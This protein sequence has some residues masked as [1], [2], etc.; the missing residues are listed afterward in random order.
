[1]G[2]QMDQ[3]TLEKAQDALTLRCREVFGDPDRWI[4]STGYPKSMAL[5]VLNS[6]YS[7]GGNYSATTNV[8]ARYLKAREQEGANAYRDSTADLLAAVERWGGS[9]EFAKVIKNERPASPRSKTPV[10]KAEVVRRAAVVL[11]D[12]KAGTVEGF[13]AN[14]SDGEARESLRKAW[15][16]LPSQRSGVTYHYL[17]ILAGYDSVKPDRWVNRFITDAIGPDFGRFTVDEAIGMVKGAARSMKVMAKDLD[18]VIWRKQT[19]QKYVLDEEEV[20]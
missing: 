19:G 4:R 9:A 10:L 13:K 20:A 14:Y 8:V 17:L 1:M 3:A 7:I 15:L 2:E 11:E 6:I 5:C 18:H 16:A 12:A